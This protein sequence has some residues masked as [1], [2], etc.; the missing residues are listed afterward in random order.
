MRGVFFF[1]LYC[2]FAVVVCP[3]HSWRFSFSFRYAVVTVFLFLFLMKME[4]TLSTLSI[5]IWED[6]IS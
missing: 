2:K 6:H 5:Y 3:H 4:P 1:R